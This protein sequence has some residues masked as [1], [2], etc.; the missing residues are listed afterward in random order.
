MRVLRLA[1]AIGLA[2]LSPAAQGLWRA[3]TLFIDLE[4]T[5]RLHAWLSLT[6]PIPESTERIFTESMGC[7]AAALS[8]GASR[9]S[10]VRVECQAPIKK[11]GLRWS[12]HWDLAALSKELSRLGADT[13]DININHPRSGFSEVLPAT[14]SQLRGSGLTISYHGQLRL[15]DLHDVTLEAGIEPQQMWRVAA[16]AGL[17]LLLPLLLFAIRAGGPLIVLAGAHGLF[18]V[19]ATAWLWVTLP[20]NPAAQVPLPWNLLIVSAPMALAVWTGSRIAG[21]PRRHLFF[22]RGIRSVA[23]L[24]LIAGL[25]SVGSSTLSWTLCCA[26]AIVV[27][28]WRLR[29]A[30]R[31]RLQPVIEGELLARVRQL[32]ARA[33]TTVKSVQLIVGGE[34]LPAAFA[35]RFHDI[36][37][38]GGLRATLSRREVD[39]IV[40]HELSHVRRPS[41]VAPRGSAFLMAGA[42][43][44]AVLVPTSLEWMPLL[45]PPA[46]LLHRAI[47][48]RNEFRA[49]AD[50][51][52]WSGDPEAMITGLVRVTRSH[53][54]PLEWPRWVKPLMPHPSTVERVRALA[55]RAEI[56]EARFQELLAVSADPPAERYPV[57]G[58]SAPAGAAFSP[59]QRKRLNLK[60]T[61]MAL[62]IPIAFGVA[63]PFI[64]YIAALLIGA[65]T[66]CL[67]PEWVLLR[68]RGRARRLLC[69]RPGVFCGF[70]PS[71][72]PRLYDGSFDYDWGFAAFEGECLVFRGDRS[73]WTVTRGEVEQVW[74]AG[75][76]FNWLPRP[77]VGFRLKSGLAICLRPFDSSFG[78]AAPRAAAALLKQA[79]EW[80]T[81]A[82][83]G[84]AAASSFDFGSL[85]GQPPPR[86]TWRTLLRGVPRYAGITLVIQ[87]TI[88]AAVSGIEW[89]DPS[90]LLGPL[91]ITAALTVFMA[92]PGVRRGKQPVQSSTVACSRAA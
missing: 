14:I 10:S 29:R 77:A 30:G 27:C 56:P 25:F 50:A 90:R 5:G 63:A 69:G 89:T 39:A 85:Q 67:L 42:V 1:I 32:A 19:A 82:Q 51:A 88:L 45:L 55:A 72:E 44:L 28:F 79:T 20:L 53:G 16:V 49:D 40:S 84:S 34:D 66:A 17:I 47:R 70:S 75:G 2:A 73:T 46:F 21:G 37:L 41:L 13:L 80:H 83:A 65:L 7:P 9:S 64:G 6:V 12:A 24:M 43:V 52:A 23:F 26:G 86:Y 91:A 76:P 68:T 15:S 22:W 33:G 71:V 59:E 92:Y 58:S 8:D 61:L 3:P 87:W 78:P 74:L 4:D 57:S 35:T 62:A 31:H 36:L 11:N 38:T 48:R 18:C 54:M 60:L 81:A